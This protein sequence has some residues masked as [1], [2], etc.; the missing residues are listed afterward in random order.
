[1][2]TFLQ[3]F[4]D[5]I[6]D[7]LY[8]G[9][10]VDDLQQEIQQNMWLLSKPTGFDESLQDWLDLINHIIDNRKQQIA[11]SSQSMIFYLWFDEQASQLR[12]NLINDSHEFLPFNSNIELVPSF[13]KIVEAFWTSPYHDGI[14]FVELD[15]IPLNETTNDSSL[16]TH[17]L[18]VYKLHLIHS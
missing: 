16:S 15:D 6:E 12:F 11:K 8:I 5:V 3:H 2:T 9:V 1:M 10:S 14:P 17:V 18:Q 4:A 13:Y 7:E